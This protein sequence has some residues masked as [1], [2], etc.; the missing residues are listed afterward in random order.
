MPVYFNKIGS[1]TEKT[2]LD[3][4]ELYE[5]SLKAQEAQNASTSADM[6]NAYGALLSLIDGGRLSAS[7]SLLLGDK[8]STLKDQIEKQEDFAD[9]TLIAMYRNNY[10]RIEV[11]NRFNKIEV[12]DPDG[13]VYATFWEVTGTPEI[14]RAHTDGG[15]QTA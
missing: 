15:W 10:D 9:K 6:F 7:L 4:D 1:K 12:V 3:L 14:L 11:K 5:I 13:D 8:I 2:I